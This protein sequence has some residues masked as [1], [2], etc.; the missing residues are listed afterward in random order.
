MVL[1]GLNV[2]VPPDH[3]PPLA[4]VTEPFKV[5][6]ATDAQIA[7]FPPALALIWP[8]LVITTVSYTGEHAKES[9]TLTV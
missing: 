8:I 6:E 2:P 1:F 5:Y 4:V 3:T 7:A 9:S